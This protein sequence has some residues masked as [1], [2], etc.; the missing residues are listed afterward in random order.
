MPNSVMEG[1][2]TAGNPALNRLRVRIF[3]DGADREGMLALYTDPLIGGMTT[4]PTLM[5]KARVFGITRPS[6]KVSL[7]AVVRE[8]RSRSKSS[9]TNS[10]K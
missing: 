6:P 5:N 1:A 4:N 9:P 7:L 8:G 2:V 10:P 3:A